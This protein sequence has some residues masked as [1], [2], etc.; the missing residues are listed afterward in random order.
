MIDQLIG[1]HLYSYGGANSNAMLALAQLSAEKNASFSYFT[2][3]LHDRVK[4]MA[5]GNYSRAI[6]L[7]MNHIELDQ[8]AYETKSFKSQSLFIPQGVHCALAEPGI[9]EL[10]REIQDFQQQNNL[11]DL[12]V[13]LPSGT[14]TT[15]VYLAKHLNCRVWTVPCVGSAAYLKKQMA[16]LSSESVEIIPPFPKV[17]F[18]SLSQKLLNVYDELLRDT[19]IEFDLLYGALTWSSLFHRWR[20]FEDKPLMYIHSG[21]VEGNTSQLKRYKR[22]VC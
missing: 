8:V 9:A 3:E 16:E 10:A 5:G 1:K 18:G 2:R 20:D 15:A 13:V 7:G 14:G 12:H 19:K 11:P 6:E 17:R 4:E 21:G 22:N